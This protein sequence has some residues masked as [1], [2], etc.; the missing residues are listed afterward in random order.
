[1]VKMLEADEV[2]AVDIIVLV[3]EEVLE[4]DTT[5]LVEEVAAVD[6][7][8]HVEGADAVEII[9]MVDK[10][11]VFKNSVVEVAAHRIKKQNSRI[12]LND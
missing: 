2:V 6:L 7:I 3:E 10:A 1:M 11:V 8:V 12:N 5:V 9:C 4:V